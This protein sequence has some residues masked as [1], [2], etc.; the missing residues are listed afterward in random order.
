MLVLSLALAVAAVLLGGCDDTVNAILES[1]RNISMYATLDMNADT[2]FVRIVPIR[3]TI[4]EVVD[5]SDYA[6]RSIDLDNN[7]IVEWQDSL[8]TFSDG[9]QGLVFFA[10][11]RLFPQHTYRIE[12]SGGGSNLVT[13]AETRI[14]PI[15]SVTIGEDSAE[16]FVTPN[17]FFVV[18]KQAVEWTGLEREPLSI[19]QWYRFRRTPRSAFTDINFPFP[20]DPELQGDRIAFELD[21]AADKISL[22]DSVDTRRTAFIGIGMRITILNAEFVPPG[23]VFDSELLVQPGTFS[24]V[25]NGFGFIG[26]VGRFSVEWVISEPTVRTLG[27]LPVS[28]AFGKRPSEPAGYGITKL[29]STV[30]GEVVP[31]GSIACTA[32]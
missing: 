10:P 17:G 4:D 2:Q 12:A 30:K 26:A 8:V 28:D 6:V 24:N 5:G 31:D 16:K 15:P 19:E 7:S 1:N 3:E 9:S 14:P 23:G 29:C 13:S 21:L 18:S 11:L 25:E 20:P 32:Q 27:Y 22:E